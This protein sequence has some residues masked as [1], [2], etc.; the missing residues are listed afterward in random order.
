MYWFIHLFLH[1]NIPKVVLKT[2]VPV[3][4]VFQKA[5]FQFQGIVFEPLFPSSSFCF[6]KTKLLSIGAKWNLVSM[7]NMKTCLFPSFQT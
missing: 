6:Y 2:A 4:T 5:H 3:K 1:P 7:K